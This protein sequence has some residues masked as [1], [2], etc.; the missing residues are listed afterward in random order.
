MNRKLVLS[1]ILIVGMFFAVLAVPH[2]PIYAADH[3][4]HITSPA[5]G[6]VITKE[7]FSVK[8]TFDNA[9]TNNF[10]LIV[11]LSYNGTKLTHIYPFSVNNSLNWGPILVNAKDF[12]NLPL[13]GICNVTLQVSTKTPSIPPLQSGKVSIQ[14]GEKPAITPPTPPQHVQLTVNNSNQF[15]NISWSPS[16]AGSY[17]I[18]DY[19]IYRGTNSGKE[20]FLNPIAK[21]NS[22]TTS[23]TDKNVKIGKTYYYVIKAFDNQNPPNLSAPSVE[24]GGTLKDNIPPEITINSP[25]NNTKVNTDLVTVMGKI[26]D[27]GVGVDSVT[28]N[29]NPVAL[30]SEGAFAT[31]IALTKGTNTITIVATDKAGH[32]STK[33]ITIYYNQTNSTIMINLQIDNPLMVVN[34]VQQEIDPGRETKPV[35]IPKWG[36]T[37]VPIRAIVEALGGSISWNGKERKVTINFKG[38]VINLWIDKPKAE[39]NGVMKWIDPN[40]HDVKPIIVNSRTMLPLRFVAENLGCK[41]DWYPKT[42]A[43]TITYGP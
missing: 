32:K 33:M 24:V 17:P 14:W 42:R 10:N 20:D 30:S 38:T 18:M 2:Y 3:G 1:L 15:F 6:D 25:Q 16:T 35:I 34:G 41:V 19:L 40:N 9:Q 26:V 12:N 36:R 28:V 22:N 39:V 37:V 29:G 27:M 23:Y 4:V 7:S 8:G 31:Q 21:V 13:K 5:E 43:I 11:K